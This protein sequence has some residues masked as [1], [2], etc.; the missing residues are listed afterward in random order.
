MNLK[1][2]ITS[3]LLTVCIF[4]KAQS[5]VP[6]IK[7]LNGPE[8][9]QNGTVKYQLSSPQ[10]ICYYIGVEE[11]LDNKWRDVILDISAGAPKKAA[12]IRKVSAKQVIRGSFE[13]NNLSLVHDESGNVFRFKIN[14]GTSATSINKWVVSS[15]VKIK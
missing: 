13:F 8:F 9:K 12:I 10:A 5:P 11:L 15:A 1:L 14:Y 6:D 2:L 4:C 3:V 7:I